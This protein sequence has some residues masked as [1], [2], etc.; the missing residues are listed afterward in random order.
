M[1][2]HSAKYETVLKYYKAGLWSK[3]KVYDAVGRWITKDEYK[4]ITGEFYY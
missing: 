4:E 3:K 1:T 2:Q